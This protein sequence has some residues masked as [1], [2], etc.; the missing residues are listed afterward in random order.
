METQ[1]IE[2]LITMVSVMD[3][4]AL[5]GRFFAFHG[6]FP[7]DLS[8]DFLDRLPLDHLRH[9]FVALCIQ[10]NRLPAAA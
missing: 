9:I 4:D 3:R 1:Q 5:K 10:N 2:Q 7:V 8:E 6:S